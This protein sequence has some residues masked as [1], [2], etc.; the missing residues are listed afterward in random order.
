MKAQKKKRLR[1]TFVQAVALRL[2]MYITAMVTT[3]STMMTMFAP[4]SIIVVVSSF[5]VNE[6]TLSVRLEFCSVK[7]STLVFSSVF[8]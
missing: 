6:L 3:T 4:R 2:L 1:R 5:W 7:A 8:C